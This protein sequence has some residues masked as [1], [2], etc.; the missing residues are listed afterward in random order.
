MKK[1]NYEYPRLIHASFGSREMFSQWFTSAFGLYTFFFYESIIGLPSELAMAAFLIFAIWNAVN[2]PLIGY[3]MEKIKMP[4]QQKRDFHRFPWILIG[5]IPFIFSYLLIFLIPVSWTPETD[6]WKIFAWYVFSLILFD[7]FYS[8]YD[9]NIASLFQAKFRKPEE[10]RAVQ[11]W[12]TTLGILGLVLAFVITGM[13]VKQTQP[14]TYRQA[15]MVTFGGG[16]L[17]F[18]LLLPGAYENKRVRVQNRRMR[19]QSGD[20]DK[21]FLI[22]AKELLANQAVRAKFIMFFGYQAAVALINASALYVITYILDD[23]ENNS[24]IFIMGAMLI[25]ALISTPI[26]VSISQKVNDNKKISVIA[27]YMMF[28]SFVPMIFA[29]ELWQWVGSIALFGICLG[30]QWFMDPPT[31]GDIV[32]NGAVRTGKREPSLYYGF[33][34]FVTRFSEAFKALVIAAAHMATGFVE[35]APTLAGQQAANPNGWKLMILGVRIHTAV[36]PAIIVILATI[37]FQKKYDLTPEKIKENR[38][39]LDG[40]E[41]QDIASPE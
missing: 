21:P 34:I 2:D 20:A 13:I 6:I 8:I 23:P 1:N 15:A 28:F 19:A 14:E 38:E 33:Q 4:W 18:A 39:I 27:G 26:W 32:D 16:F 12:G 5:G 29:T 24:L 25:G 30:G 17:L 9:V 22:V 3:L 40:R 7:T 36:V 31:M 37:Y 35:G 41:K 10:R 11:G